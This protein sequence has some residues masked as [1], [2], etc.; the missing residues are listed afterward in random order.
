MTEQAQERAF[1]NEEEER[2]TK[3]KDHSV[4][5]PLVHAQ[6]S[7]IWGLIPATMTIFLQPSLHLSL[8]PALGNS[9]SAFCRHVL[10]PTVRS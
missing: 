9:I 2:C 3:K 8:S 4:I 1:E 6:A 5:E 10:L 7:Q